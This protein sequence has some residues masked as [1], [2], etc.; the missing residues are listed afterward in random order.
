MQSLQEIVQHFISFVLFDYP[1]PL[2]Y[3]LILFPLNYWRNRDLVRI[4]YICSSGNLL[5][6]PPSTH[7]LSSGNSSPTLYPRRS[8][9]QGDLP[10]S[11]KGWSKTFQI[12]FL[13]KNFESNNKEI[14][15]G[16]R[17]KEYLLVISSCY[18]PTRDSRFL[19][20]E[21]DSISI[22]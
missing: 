1:N 7:F 4:S 17:W 12:L 21:K 20:L 14:D 22:L 18:R 16:S 2:K 19:P 6:L 8:I 10:S 9:I 3:V 11:A 5:A 13:N 15:D